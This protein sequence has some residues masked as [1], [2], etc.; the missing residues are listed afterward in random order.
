MILQR[1]ALVG[2]LLSFLVLTTTAAA[3]TA[4]P[5]KV[6]SA[7]PLALQC[8][9]ELRT[10]PAPD[11]QHI[12]YERKVRLDGHQDLFMCAA[13]IVSGAEPIC[14][15][16]PQEMPRGFDA[17]A[18]SYLYPLSWSPD[19][20]EIVVVGQPLITSLD[21]DLWIM[22]L[23]SST[24]TNLTDD[25]YEGPLVKTA[26]S[27]GAPAGVSVEVQPA[28]SPDGTQ[29]A[30]ERT[31]MAAVGEFAPS[32][33]SLVNAATGEI[34]DI[35]PLPGHEDQWVDAGATTSIAWSPD[36]S[37]L[38]VSLRH[39]DP[40]PDYDG[41]WVVDVESG[42]LKQLVSLAAV[43]DLFSG[44]FADVPADMVGPVAWSPD[45]TALLVWVSNPSTKPVALWAFWVEVESGKTTALP[46]PAHPKDTGTRRG[47]WPFQAAWS[48]DGASIL[49][50]ANGL[51]PDDDKIL[52]DPNNSRVRVSVYL[53]NREMAES[54]LLGHLPTGEAIPFYFASWSNT[55]DVILD[56]YHLVM[57]QE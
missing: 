34:T 55:G 18:S 42:T 44:I 53:V 37:T 43:E 14:L 8:G 23:N 19:S 26:D 22:D 51:H 27:S 47:I 20:T 17:D 45:G 35:A 15:E 48:P 24:W 49:V 56:G 1:K 46:L 29:I 38:A 12:A 52:L 21:T 2:L 16:P 32:T 54:T 6:V 7:T 5:W 39:R 30:V 28:W 4:S 40:K 25:G 10:F 36:S 11:G 50:A 13:D 33:L 57:E 3:Q 9:V 41:V 31:V